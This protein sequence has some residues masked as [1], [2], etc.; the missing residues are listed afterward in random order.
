MEKRKIILLFLILI[1][2]LAIAFV[3]HQNLTLVNLKNCKD[4]LQLFVDHNYYCSLIAYTLIYSICSALP[5]PGN[6]L[7]SLAGGYFF[8]IIKTMV[9]VNIALCLGIVYDYLVLSYFINPEKISL[10]NPRL[11]KIMINIKRNGATY[12]FAL[13]LI[14]VFPVFVINYVAIIS[15]VSL[16][17]LL[18]TT[19]I[20]IL[21][22]AFIYV[23]AGEKLSDIARLSDVLQVDTFLILAGIAG[24]SL[25]PLVFKNKLKLH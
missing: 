17:T 15:G 8:G 18:I 13:R 12:L 23:S 3:A 5:I 25:L 7:L 21:P 2:V 6:A 4:R 19:S 14:P 22:G 9:A 1:L 10:L 16:L 11:K 20:G 24:L